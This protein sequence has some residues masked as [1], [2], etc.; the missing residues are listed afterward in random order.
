M[1]CSRIETQEVLVHQAR[2]SI[3][4][5]DSILI[6]VGTM[7]TLDA[8]HIELFLCEKYRDGSWEYELTGSH[9][10]KKRASGASAAIFDLKHLKDPSSCGN[11]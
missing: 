7:Q 3:H 9:D 11:S 8:R 10:V 5:L 1:Y 2:R 6:Y 4:D